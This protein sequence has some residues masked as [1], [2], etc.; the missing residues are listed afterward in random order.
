MISR[1]AENQDTEAIKDKLRPV[2]ELLNEP[3]AA[4]MTL[5]QILSRCNLTMEEYEQCLQCMNKKTAIIMKRD[6]Q[7]CLINNYNPVLLESWNSNLDVSFV[8]NSYSCIEYLRKYI[9]KQESGLSEY[10]KTVMDNANVDQ[11]NECDEMK[12]V[13]Q[14]YSKKREVSAQECVTRSCGLK[15]KNSSRSVIFVPTDD[16]PLKMS[17]PMSFLESTTPDSENIW[18]TSLNDKYKSRP[19]TP[20]YEEMCLADFASTCR[21]VSSQE[22]KR[23]GVHPLLNQLG[24]VQRRKKPLVIRY[25]HCSE[26]KDPEQFCGRNLRLYLPHRSELELKR[27]NYPTYQSFYNHG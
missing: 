1:P 16:N 24:Y 10:L 8:L 9:T 18:M 22:A 14:A 12:A 19:E 5:Q 6:P 25:Y 15:M 2:M 7:S 4:S 20:E 17:R 11:V 23:K 13:M 21:F 3:E 27:P 26:E